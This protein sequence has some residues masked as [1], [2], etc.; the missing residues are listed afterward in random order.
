MDNKLAEN[1][2][3]F[4]VKNLS[5]ASKKKLSEQTPVVATPV[6]D[7]SVVDGVKSMLSIPN[8]AAGKTVSLSDDDDAIR[9]ITINAEANTP[10]P[11]GITLFGVANDATAVVTGF[12]GYN[13][14][15][16]NIGQYDTE[17]KEL[18]RLSK[19]AYLTTGARIV[20]K[21]PLGNNYFISENGIAALFAKLCLT[22]QPN[23]DNA[24]ALYTQQ[25][26]NLIKTF[27][28]C[29]LTNTAPIPVAGDPTRDM[30]LAAFNKNVSGYISRGVKS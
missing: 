15:I 24:G 11:A 2:L 26:N 22:V 25:Y 12:G 7:A 16:G 23:I 14:V 21:I 9:V 10:V 27:K 30:K 6:V 1:M 8:I 4:G 5:E 29:T 19:Q 18:I 13:L 28:F 20:Y 17:K 3:R